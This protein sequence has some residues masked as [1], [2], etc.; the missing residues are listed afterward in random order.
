MTSKRCSNLYSAASCDI[1]SDGA[2]TV[3]MKPL[4]VGLRKAPA[5]GSNKGLNTEGAG[6]RGERPVSA[7]IAR[8]LKPAA[9]SGATLARL[10]RVSALG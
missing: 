9:S 5:R 1:R 2:R 3:I 10:A 7:E 6:A 4:I 8:T